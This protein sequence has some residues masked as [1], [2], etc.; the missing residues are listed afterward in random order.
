[1][2]DLW[3][4][5]ERT[6]AVIAEALAFARWL[7]EDRER[8]EDFLRFVH[9]T[10]RAEYTRDDLVAMIVPLILQCERNPVVWSGEPDNAW[11]GKAMR[12]AGARI[13]NGSADRLGATI[14]EIGHAT[15]VRDKV[16]A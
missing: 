10:R 7:E 11:R 14:S 1:M 3:L 2:T 15:L 5:P 4:Y 6:D 8:L 9:R 13:V 16:A 12:G